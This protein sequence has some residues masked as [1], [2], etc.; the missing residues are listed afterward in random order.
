[1]AITLRPAVAADLPRIHSLDHRLFPSDIAFDLETFTLYFADP[2]TL[3]LLAEGDDGAMGGFIMM[4]FFGDHEL[5]VESVDVD[6]ACQ[7]QGVGRLMME[8]VRQRG[9]ER[10]VKEVTLQ[11]VADDERAQSF[12]RSLGY[13]V[14]RTL[15]GYYA[16]TK[17]AIEMSLEL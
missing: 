16:G 7:R 5:S 17:D 10:G 3:I 6:P 13:R 15:A 2:E 8:A 4:T 1:M 9:I 12:Y 11:V 14:V